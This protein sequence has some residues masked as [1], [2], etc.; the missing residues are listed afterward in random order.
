MFVLVIGFYGF[1]ADL[2]PLNAIPLKC[3]SI[4]DQEC[5]VKSSIMNVN[6][7]ESLFYPYRILVNK[8]SI[9]YNGNHNPY[10]E[11]C[12]PHAVKRM[13]IKVFNPMSRIN[14]THQISYIKLVHVNVD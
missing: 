10:A 1:N 7:N 14:E 8:G 6:S 3:V 5:K 9:S 12:V 13:N 2:N 4:N 11:L